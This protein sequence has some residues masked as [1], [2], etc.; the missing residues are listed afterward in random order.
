MYSQ[1]RCWNN[2]INSEGERK[3]IPGHKSQTLQ[4]NVRPFHKHYL[5]M[6]VNCGVGTDDLYEENRIISTQ[7]AFEISTDKTKPPT[8]KY[9][10]SASPPSTS[11]SWESQEQ[12]ALYWNT[13]YP[14]KDFSTNSQVCWWP[15]YVPMLHPQLIPYGCKK[16]NKPQTNHSREEKDQVPNQNGNIG[17]QPSSPTTKL[18][19]SAISENMY[20]NLQFSID[21]SLDLCHYLLLPHE[22][23][24]KEKLPRKSYPDRPASSWKKGNFPRNWNPPKSEQHRILPKL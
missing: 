3:N 4:S 14:L 15:N 17:I 6:V 12:Q 18:I 9:K 20:N 7:E 13:V 1:Y 21:H 23:S 2:F 16:K 8:P 5:E 22:V 11:F 24:H 10:P 19:S